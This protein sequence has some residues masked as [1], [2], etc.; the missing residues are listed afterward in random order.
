MTSVWTPL[1]L[2]PL[3][4]RLRVTL[5]NGQCFGW[6][7]HVTSDHPDSDVWSGV[8]ADCI[9]HLRET[10]SDVVYRCLPPLT[11][12]THRDQFDARLRD[13]L[14]A[15]SLSTVKL[16]A[17][18]AAAD[19][20]FAARAPYLTGMRLLRQDPVECLFSF[21]CSSNNN[22]PRIAQVRGS[23]ETAHTLPV[24]CH[25]PQCVVVY[26]CVCRGFCLS[27]MCGSAAQMLT[28]LRRTYG[29]PIGHDPL[30]GQA[31]FSFP[32]VEAL[33]THATEDALRALGFGY[34]A[35]F[36]V[37]SARQV[38]ALGGAAWLTG[39][40]TQPREQV[41]LA[42]LPLQGVGPKVADC[43]ALFSLD[44]LAVV[45]VDVHVW[46]IASQDYKAEF[47]IDFADRSLTPK[48]YAAV[49]D[50]FRA[51]FGE[52]AGYAHSVLFTAD[53][54][55]FQPLF[56]VALRRVAP[57]KSPKKE[58][59]EKKAKQE[60]TDPTDQ[61]DQKGQ[62][63][64]TSQTGPTAAAPPSAAIGRTTITTRP[65]AA[66]AAAAAATAT[67][68]TAAAEPSVTGPPPA[69]RQRK[70]QSPAVPL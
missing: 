59:K 47:P 46:K 45:P 49:G 69:K 34:R 61:A 60:K 7:P 14:R 32:T 8:V 70:K 27:A 53:L 36:I 2:A 17:Q 16:F 48:I 21:L 26:V 18:W 63:D 68:A 29:L 28:A 22:I 6:T 43:V 66:A 24:W 1:R 19:A 31:H 42:L 57:P 62:T 37:Q 52:L 55:A 12:P 4:L 3:E 9:V 41:Q 13:L 30:S 38:V 40:R 64:Q 10:P 25:V 51:R 56:P 15:D 54:A 50:F 65:A 35:K 39:L 11:S 20:H 23:L 67:G 44:Q 58:K 33:A 5:A